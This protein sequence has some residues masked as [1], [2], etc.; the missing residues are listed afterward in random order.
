MSLDLN[1]LENLWVIM[2]CRGYSNAGHF[3][4]LDQFC[5]VVAS[6][7]ELKLEE[8]IQNLFKSFLRRLVQVIKKKEG[9]TNYQLCIFG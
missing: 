2:V 5:E 6:V 4:I 7:W 8:Y 9:L 3:K 1:I